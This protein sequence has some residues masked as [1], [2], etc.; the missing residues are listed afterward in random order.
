MPRASPGS[1]EERL[2]VPKPNPNR[3]AKCSRCRCEFAFPRFE[4]CPECGSER[5][6]FVEE[7]MNHAERL[8][9]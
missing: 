3:I 9:Q 7:E 2:I 4:V 8:P 6:S 5:F 1:F